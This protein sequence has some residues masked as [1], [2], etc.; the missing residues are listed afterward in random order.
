MG[1]LQLARQWDLLSYS[2]RNN[3]EK[4]VKFLVK[5]IKNL[6]VLANKLLVVCTRN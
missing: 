2:K 3:R 5:L 6:C 1:K 4:L